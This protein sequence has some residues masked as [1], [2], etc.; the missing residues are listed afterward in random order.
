MNASLICEPCKVKEETSVFNEMF[1][2]R[3][4][5]VEKR[6]SDMLLHV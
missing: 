5:L 4:S 6:H 2:L 1:I 3:L